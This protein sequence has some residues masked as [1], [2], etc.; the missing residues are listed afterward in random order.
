MA[1]LIAP[2]KALSFFLDQEPAAADF[3]ADVISGLSAAPKNLPPKHFYDARGSA[4]FEQICETSEYYVT[5]TELSL[6]RVKAGEMAEA[7]GAD[8]SIIE[9]GSGASEKI[10]LLLDEAKSPK[11]YVAIDISREFLIQSAER[12]AAER[13]DLAVGAVCADFFDEIRLPENV[14]T[15]ARRVGYFPGS[16]IGNFEP[17]AASA[18][19][20]RAR[21]TLGRGSA[22]LLGADLIK[23][24]DVLLAAYDDA[25]GVTAR[26]NKNVL[27]R[28]RSELDAGVDPDDFEHVVRWNADLARMEMHLEACREIEI[29]LDGAAFGFAKGETI[30]TESSHKYDAARLEA[31]AADAGWRVETVWSDPRHWFCV[32]L[33]V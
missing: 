3:R 33:L 7:I 20:A 8:A 26:F 5:R 18:F 2:Y 1:E 30:H 24:E 6:M 15:G 10:A 28:M 25:A 32:A 23:D 12:V 9:Y 13:T 27:H 31:L 21:E 19:L 16:T 14:L 22:F 29:D 11:D 17:K 4:L